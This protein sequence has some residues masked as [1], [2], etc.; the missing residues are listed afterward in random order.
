MPLT[1]SVLLEHD[2]DSLGFVDARVFPVLAR[3]LAES[4]FEVLDDADVVHDES[5]RCVAEHPVDTGD[6]LQ[7]PMALHGL[8]DVPAFGERRVVG[9]TVIGCE[10]LD[11]RSFTTY[12]G[13]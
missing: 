12:I 5:G 11:G 2:G 6:G 7:E 10:L 9:L 1:I 8:I 13:R 3:I 4:R